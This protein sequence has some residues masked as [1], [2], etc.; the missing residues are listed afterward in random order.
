M[1]LSMILMKN[2]M[3]GAMEEFKKQFGKDTAASTLLDVTN[4]ETIEKA[5]EMQHLLL[6]VLILLLT[7]QASAF[8]NQLQI[9]RLKIGINYIIFW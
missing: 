3:Q 7:M 6:A 8:Q 4:N 2:D 9:I 5:F 1:L